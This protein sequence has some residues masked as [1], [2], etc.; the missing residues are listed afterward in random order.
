MRTEITRLRW[1]ALLALID[2]L[3]VLDGLLIA[4]GLRYSEHQ[5]PGLVAAPRFP[6]AWVPLLVTLWLLALALARSHDP[7]HL[8]AGHQMYRRIFFADSLALGALVVYTYFRE[9]PNISR[10][11]LLF[12]W[13]L[14]LAFLCGARWVVRQGIYRRAARGERLNRVLVVGANR[15]GL[16]IAEQLTRSRSA[17]SHVVGFLDD[18]HPIGRE[19]LPGLRVL[20]EPMQL[21]AVARAAGASHAVVVESGISWESHQWLVRHGDRSDSVRV[22]M[23]PGLYDLS[24]T[25]M[26][27]GQLGPVLLIKP[28][29]TAITGLEATL[30]RA[31]DVLGASLLLL[32]TAP[33]LV[34]IAWRLRPRVFVLRRALGHRGRPFNLLEFRAHSRMRQFHL[35]RLPSLLNVLAGSMSLV[36]PRPVPAAEAE[37]LADWRPLLE[38]ARPGFIGPWWLVGLFRPA[39]LEE[40]IMLD[41]QYLRNYTIW[42]DLHVLVQTVR[43]LLNPAAWGA[44]LLPTE[45]SPERPE[46]AA[47]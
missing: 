4:R 34:L 39:N 19:L 26:E 47:A 37:G 33:L 15:H 5:L 25:R 22:M 8:I 32:V 36:G 17:S 35:S 38:A 29:S 27:L 31:L 20:G 1:H 46:P 24:T 6:I 13:I 3:A 45:P 7:N 16:A 11:F 2:G 42:F 9:T 14:V 18:F 12:A 23:A 10:G 44:S 28:G 21:F 41:L 43:G 40:E 30:K